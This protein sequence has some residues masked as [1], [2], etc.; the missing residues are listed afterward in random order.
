MNSTHFATGVGLPIV[1]FSLCLLG[2]GGYLCYFA[3]RR[4][5][6]G[7]HPHCRHC[8][9]QLTGI[10]NKQTNCPECGSDLTS[11]KAIAQGNRT[12]S[13]PLLATGILLCILALGLTGRVGYMI[14]QQN[15]W[16][17]FKPTA[18]VI[19]DAIS[20]FNTKAGK[21]S[22]TMELSTRVREHA[23]TPSQ[24]AELID[25][26]I[27]FRTDQNAWNMKFR[28]RQIM[29]ELLA[30][31]M[32]TQSQI[33]QLVDTSIELELEI[34]PTFR[35]RK[36]IPIGRQFTIHTIGDEHGY[37]YQ[38]KDHRILLDDRLIKKIATSDKVYEAKH[39]TGSGTGESLD[40]SRGPLKKITTGTYQLTYSRTMHITFPSD[41]KYQPFDITKQYIKSIT[42]KDKNAII[43]NFI[44]DEQHQQTMDQA[45]LETR[46]VTDEFFTKVWLRMETVPVNLAMNVLIIDGSQE[47]EVGSLHWDQDQS[48]RW[49][50]IRSRKHFDLSDTA[51]VVLRPSQD[52]A[53]LQKDISTYW[54]GQL[55]RDGVAV[56]APYDVPFNMDTSIADQMA[57]K[58]ELRAIKRDEKSDRVH[59]T[60]GFH[61]VATNV[62][63]IP[64]YLI[65]GRW[66][67]DKRYLYDDMNITKPAYNNSRFGARCTIIP[68]QKTIS[69][70][71]VPNKDWEA[72]DEHLTPPWG[73][74]IEFLDIPLPPKG[75]T[76]DESHKSKVVLMGKSE[77]TVKE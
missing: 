61:E 24:Y 3:K 72:R 44:T 27:K 69:I 75:K 9:Y 70:R 6:R 42:I 58:I 19:R 12:T 7:R 67:R 18:W 41:S 68:E 49:H 15:A 29:D 8:D 28:W 14:H 32:F 60:F 20:E 33:Q 13:W 31:E 73:H 39:T 37:F 57:E 21:D 48:R 36:S 66:Q 63:Y 26:I 17:K 43:D 10:T 45:W 2:L 56:N 46:I 77:T 11:P 59:M 74:G 54:G 62:D 53:D 22:N 16:L 40:L 5:R 35:Q 34:K 23:L 25:H 51:S 65:D 50:R 47:Y 30:F 71:L 55:R 38:T 52:V 64:M 1:I 76:S 4:K